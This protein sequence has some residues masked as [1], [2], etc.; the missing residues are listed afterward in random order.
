M[1]GSMLIGA[2]LTH[3]A[4]RFPNKVAL[5]CDR[6]T[7]T[8]AGL[9]ARANQTANLL[10]AAG[11]A[12]GDRVVLLGHGCIDWVVAFEGI[13]K[14]GAVA[15]PINTRLTAE[16][17]GAMLADCGARIVFAT[18]DYA[19]A[20]ASV[21]ATHDVVLLDG[22]D[23]PLEQRLAPHSDR[24]GTVEIHP[25]DVMLI[26]YTG[27]T[28]GVAKGV[29]LSHANL[30]WNNLN[31]IIDTE[32]TERDNTLLAT[33]LHHSAALN[34]WLLPHL[35]LGATATI[36]P[37]YS[38]EAFVDAIERQRA[39]NGFSP[40][41]MAR[42]IVSHPAIRDRDLSSFR[43]WYIGGGNLPRKDRDAIHA[44]FPGL[45]IFYQYGLT[46][47]GPIVTVLK[48]EDYE[49][50]PESIGRAFCNCSVAILRED[51]SLAEVGE[52]GEVAMRGPQRMIGYHGRPEATAAVFHGEWLR[53]GD[54]GRMDEDGFVYFHD[55]LKD[56]VKT[57]GLNVYSQK[58]ELALIQHPAIQ[59]VAIVGVPSERWGEEVVAAVVLREGSTSDEAEI[60]AFAKA[61]L[62]GYEVPKR[63]V[64]VDPSDMPIN[65]SG[66]IVKRDL[67]RLVNRLIEEAAQ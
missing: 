58:V 56:M 22:E 37:K 43:R 59:E 67:R 2:H 25:D 42:E 28:T 17:V 30:F 55:R 21:L 3:N 46:E 44:R 63:V 39:T 52:V 10:A 15:V 16:E 24:P 31:E 9:E 41:A 19:K 47:A 4:A 29:M 51:L 45:R 5:I 13:V 49:K 26:L 14:R 23:D 33:P 54:M 11:V 64:F 8:Y 27:G 18:P 48:E 50:A 62:A 57:G 38:P 32:M 35:Q 53:T 66:K 6:T 60:I 12:Q 7:I 1:S 40:P 20:F 36:L 61:R 65:Y 34:C